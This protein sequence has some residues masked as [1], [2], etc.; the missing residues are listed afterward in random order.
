MRTGNDTDAEVI[1]SAVDD[2][3]DAAPDGDVTLTVPADEA[4]DLTAQALESGDEDFEGSFGDGEGKW[5]LGVHSDRA[6]HV[7]S[8]VRSRWGY[9]SSLSQ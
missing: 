8:L 1:L 6:L 4:R 3:G 9:L 2:D 5:R 7:L